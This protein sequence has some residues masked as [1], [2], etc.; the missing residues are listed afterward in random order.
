MSILEIPQQHRIILTGGPGVGKTSILKA[1]E[2]RKFAVVH[3]AATDVIIEEQKQGIDK[4][5]LCQ[6]FEDKVIAKQQAR[7]F[8]AAAQKAHAIFFDRSPFDTETYAKHYSRTTAVINR[9]INHL[10]KTNYYN[11]TAFLI[12]SLGFITQDGIR[13]ED[14]GQT[15][16]IEEKLTQQYKLHGFNVIRIPSKKCCGKGLLTPEQ[17]ADLIIKHLLA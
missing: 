16:I 3:E 11:K 5:Q 12:E 7:Q 10:K 15:R 6:G 8:E 4:P 13:C 1:L 17:R 2:A 14:E 9:E